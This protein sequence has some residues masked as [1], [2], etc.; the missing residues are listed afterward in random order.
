[1]GIAWTGLKLYEKVRGQQNQ[2]WPKTEPFQA[3]RPDSWQAQHRRAVDKPR[4]RPA[5]HQP[6]GIGH[7][8]IHKAR[9]RK[10]KRTIG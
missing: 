10:G 8:K 7:A 6:G 4:L 2:G 1:M 9:I 3:R 5:R